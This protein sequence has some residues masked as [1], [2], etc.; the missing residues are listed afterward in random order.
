MFYVE[1]SHQ[2]Y[3]QGPDAMDCPRA[4]FV[5]CPFHAHLDA[6]FPNVESVELIFQKYP[7]QSFASATPRCLGR[8]R[9]EMSPG[10]DRKFNRLGGDGKL[11]QHHLLMARMA[12]P[13]PA[14]DAGSNLL[15]PAMN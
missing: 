1:T 11:S 12:N 14:T 2:G 15:E 8:E 4:R 7:S 5:F 13:S 9:R 6:A 3:P 10:G